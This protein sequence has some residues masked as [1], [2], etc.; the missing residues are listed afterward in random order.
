MGK[1][2]EPLWGPSFESLVGICNSH[3]IF[4][5]LIELFRPSVLFV[6]VIEQDGQNDD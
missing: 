6:L 2:L 5:M 4:R 3:C 1:K